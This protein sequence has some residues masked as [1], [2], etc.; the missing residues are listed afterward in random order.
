MLVEILWKMG[1]NKKIAGH[2]SLGGSFDQDTYTH[3]PYLD[4]RV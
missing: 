2:F 3:R 4:F 1:E